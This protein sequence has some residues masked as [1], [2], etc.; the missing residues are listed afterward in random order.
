[1]S[2]IIWQSPAKE[3]GII[4]KVRYKHLKQL[5]IYISLYI[6]YTLCIISVSIGEIDIKHWRWK[7]GDGGGVGSGEEERFM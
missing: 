3:L 6:S 1:M 5:E 2:K 7:R 4:R